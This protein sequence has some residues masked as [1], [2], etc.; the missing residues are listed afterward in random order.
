MKKHNIF[1]LISKNSPDLAWSGDRCIFLTVHGSRAYGTNTP[2]SDT[3]IKGIVIPPSKYYFSTLHKIEQIELKAPNPDA[4]L[5]EIRKFFNLALSNNPSII[6]VLHT[7]PS[8]HLIVTEL[9]KVILDHKDEFLSK[10]IR[11]SFAGFA[12]SQLHRIKQHKRW[13]TTSEE[14]NP[15]YQ[16]WKANRNPKIFAMEEKFGYN[17]KHAYH[18]VRLMRMCKEA[19]TTGKIIVKRPDREELLSI[20]D[21]AWSYDRLLEFADTEDKIIEGLYET[22]TALPH[23]P[24]KEKLDKICIKLVERSLSMDIL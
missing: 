5:Y 17:T 12:H 23:A 22:S 10:N 14:D 4:C 9:G 21:G 19:L 8:D 1:D 11:H 3:D 20:R 6:E 2:E 16:E 13:M 18:L 7:D 24:D 15:K